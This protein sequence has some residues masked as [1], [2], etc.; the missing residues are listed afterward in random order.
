MLDAGIDFG[1]L[2]RKV[3]TG[4]R[5]PRHVD[6]C[7]RDRD[8]VVQ[9][10]HLRA[11]VAHDRFQ[12]QNGGRDSAEARTYAARAAWNLGKDLQRQARLLS[13]RWG[14]RQDVGEADCGCV[15]EDRR[16]LA[17]EALCRVEEG[18]RATEWDL[19]L[20]VVDA[21]GKPMRAWQSSRK[22]VGLRG[23]RDAV[24]RVRRRA[25]GLLASE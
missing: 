9:E 20:E 12:T 15:D 18:L 3:V 10:L 4:L 1:V 24:S 21:G 14:T 5:W 19:L 8:D 2:A 23:Y 16:W 7:S 25:R 6:A 13:T 17:A 22:V 11:W